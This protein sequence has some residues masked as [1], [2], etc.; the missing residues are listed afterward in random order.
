MKQQSLSEVFVFDEG[1]HQ[2]LA[3]QC[4]GHGDGQNHKDRA[5]GDNRE[6]ISKAPQDRPGLFY[7]PNAVER[8]FDIREQGQNRGNQKNQAISSESGDIG[9]VDIFNNFSDCGTAANGQ[10][11]EDKGLEFVLDAESFQNRKHQGQQGHKR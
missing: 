7:R 5:D 1:D 4:T 8:F 11:F 3:L 6:I 10:L 9:I 2:L